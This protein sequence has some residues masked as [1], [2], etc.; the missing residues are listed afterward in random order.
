[1]VNPL[2]ILHI[3][4]THL[5]A[6]RDARMRG[7]NT[8]ETLVATLKH[9]LGDPRPPDVI[10][11]TGDIVQD[12]TRAGYERFRDLTEKLGPPVY[13]LP[14][15]HD[16][17]GIMREVLARKPFQYCGFAQHAGWSL[18]MLN[19]YASKDDGGRLAPEELEFLDQ[20]LAASNTG[21]C[22]IAMHHQP[23]PM[24]SRWLDSV[25]LRNADDFLAICDRH[26]GVRGIV[27]GH[28]HQ[29]SDRERNGVRLMSTPS[30][31]AQ[32]KPG[33]DKFALDSRP[34]GY[35]WI[36]LH[37]NGSIDTSIAWV[38]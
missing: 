13:C 27:W 10:L 9:A 25:A 23:V 14:G 15:N 20:S 6:L 21:H 18:V 29:A 28:V 33:S 37:A 32:F 22:L 7:V 30:T 35:R 8:D 24:G 19:T 36:D 26:G 4:D 38:E 16:S 31:C 2:R 1:M 12:E 34:P 5:H 3:T 11:A 17:P